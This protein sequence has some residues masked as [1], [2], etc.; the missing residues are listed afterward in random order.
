MGVLGC[1]TRV[2][3]PSVGFSGLGSFKGSQGLSAIIQLNSN[4]CF[5]TFQP[6]PNVFW[7]TFCIAPSNLNSIAIRQIFLIRK[8]PE[9][10]PCDKHSSTRRHVR[11]AV[12]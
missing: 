2:R 10:F 12:Q 8:D 5:L 6:N 3:F 11:R 7:I 1:A 4:Y 9:T